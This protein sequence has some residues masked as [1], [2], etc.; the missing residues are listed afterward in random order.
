MFAEAILSAAAVGLGCGA[1]CGTGACGSSAFAFLSGSI[2]AEGNGLSSALRQGFF[3]LLGKLLAVAGLCAASA[4]VGTQILSVNS[5]SLVLDKLPYGVLLAA[6]LWLLAGWMHHRR[7]CHGC[8]Q[9]LGTQRMLPA[10]AV[11]AAFGAAPCAP[12]LMVLG[13]AA[14]LSVPGAPVLG[15]VFALASSL[16]PSVFTLALAGTLSGKLARELGKVLPWF[17]LAVY[18]LFLGA[19]IVGLCG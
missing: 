10:F 16:I 17:Q 1:G 11:G 15:L 4:L 9:R 7:G 12:L 2:L 3:F 5:D 13:Y 14:L 19:A 18:L 8:K 6:A